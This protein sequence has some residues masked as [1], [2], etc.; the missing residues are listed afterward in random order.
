MNYEKNSTIKSSF[1]LMNS[2]KTLKNDENTEK[3]HKLSGY[4]G[5]GHL[6]KGIIPTTKLP[7]I[8]KFYSKMSDF[9][10]SPQTELADLYPSPY[11]V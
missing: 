5:T 4:H 10:G 3:E 2:E 11:T 7:G 6:C 8:E 9:L 1:G